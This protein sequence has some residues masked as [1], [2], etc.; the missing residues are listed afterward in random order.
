MKDNARRTEEAEGRALTKVVA[1]ILGTGMYT[2]VALYLAGLILLFAKGGTA[3]ALSRQYFHSFGDFFSGLVTLDAR[4]F[5]YLGTITLLLT[6]V[7][8]VFISIFAFWRERDF[9]FV[10]ITLIV[11]LVIVASVL[12]GS[13]FKINL[14]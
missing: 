13:V 7:S 6:P 12:V 1:F 9:K 11:F 14:G 2:T 8:R 3:P 10:G 5:L 4:A